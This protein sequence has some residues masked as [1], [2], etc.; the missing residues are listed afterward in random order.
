MFF[1]HFVSMDA[2]L[3]RVVVG[4]YDLLHDDGSEQYSRVEE[5]IVHPD[6]NGQLGEG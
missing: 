3:F 2:S 1:S 4:E 6:W 5:I